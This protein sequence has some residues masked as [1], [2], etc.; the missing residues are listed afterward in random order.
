M[1]E[2]T[3][4]QVIAIGVIAAMLLY[5]IVGP[6]LS[7]LDLSHLSGIESELRKIREV[8]ERREQGGK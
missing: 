3:T 1:S 8:L 5:G 7:L 4:P 6:W 2:L